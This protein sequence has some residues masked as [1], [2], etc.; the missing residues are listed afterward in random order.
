MSTSVRLSDPGKFR[1]DLSVTVLG[2]TQNFDPEMVVTA[3]VAGFNSGSGESFKHAVMCHSGH[4][5]YAALYRTGFSNLFSQPSYQNNVVNPYVASLGQQYAGLY[6]TS[7]RAYPDVCPLPLCLAR[8]ITSS[9]TLNLSSLLIHLLVDRPGQQLCHCIRCIILWDYFH[10]APSTLYF[11][12]CGTS[13]LKGITSLSSLSNPDRPRR[14]DICFHTSL[15][16]SH[17]IAQRLSVEKG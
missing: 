13:N 1:V 17:R 8:F 14:R 2:A 11:A 5:L 15:R 6:N 12:Y 7:G 10:H 16:Q 3:D 4:L 9:L